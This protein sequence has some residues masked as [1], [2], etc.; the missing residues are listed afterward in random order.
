MQYTLKEPRKSNMYKGISG[1]YVVILFTYWTLA[2][3]GYWAFGS[4][5]TPYLLSSFTEPKWAI[6]LSNAFAILQIAGCYQVY[7]V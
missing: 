2:G 4:A 1:A 3:V 6:V 7:F 5:V